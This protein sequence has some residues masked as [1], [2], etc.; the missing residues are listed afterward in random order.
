MDRAR[1]SL[2]LVG[3]TLSLT[4]ALAAAGPARAAGVCG[5]GIVESGEECD[6]GGELR[7]DGNPSMAACT[8]GAQC[9]GGINCY[10][11]F[12][13]CKFNCQ[14][15]GQGASC[16]DGNQ[17]TD[18]DHCDNVGRCVGQFKADGTACDD[19]LFCNGADTCQI[20][21]CV[22]HAG[23]PCSAA[24][25]CQTTCNE[26]TDGC[27]STPFVPCGDDGNACT[28]DVCNGSGT[29][30][31][32]PLPGGT[33]CRPAA[34]G[35]DVAETCAGGGAPC[36]PNGFVPDGTSCGDLCTT[37]G[38][39]QSGV[40]TGGTPLVCDDNDVCNGLETCTPFVGCQPGTPLDCSDGNSCTAD[41]CD[42][43]G[44]CGNPVLADG[45]PCDDG[46]L[47]TII[48]ICQGGVCQGEDLAFIA[49]SS[50]KLSTHAFVDGH[51]AVNDPGGSAKLGSAS[52][53]AA[54]SVLTADRVGLG[55]AA[56]VWDVETNL[57]RAPSATIGGTVSPATLPVLPTWCEMPGGTCGGSDIVVAERGVTRLTPGS[58]GK[59]LVLKRG[60]VEFD[61]GEY[62]IC[63]IR[64]ASPAAI[65]PRGNVIARIH[66][67][68]KVGRFGLI[69][70]YAGSA[71]LWV[72]GKGKIL[73]SSGVHAAAVRTP[74]TTLKL[75]RFVD[76][77]GGI[78]AAN[79]RGSRSVRLGCPLLP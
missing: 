64:T 60:T 6:P 58:Y 3:L 40:C 8:T 19:G 49:Q 52:V 48:D 16:F 50:A 61:P 12:S 2:T 76:F 9:A 20:G 24:T 74:D 53:M 46:N 63:S 21:E 66:G 13:C 29:C 35:C 79:L 51:L 42:P 17:C 72:S 56:S 65:R 25:D 71:E 28:D 44:G 31:H 59:I 54:G 33:V 5:N 67:D 14:F 41:Q 77:E 75:G 38:T 4:M 57:L 1:L 23:D 32:P 69:E 22:G 62:D 43:L 68:L 26:A 39:C 55:K 27:E 34:T 47:C 11:T 30:T 37:N 7:C 18:G 73:T 15:V 10:F 36:P 78:C 70:P 45:S